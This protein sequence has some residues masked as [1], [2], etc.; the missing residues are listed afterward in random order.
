MADE[1]EF[2]WQALCHNTYVLELGG[3]Y[4]LKWMDSITHTKT[5]GMVTITGHAACEAIKQRL[6]EKKEKFRR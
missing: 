6:I 1:P 5:V 2:D 4:V 3:T